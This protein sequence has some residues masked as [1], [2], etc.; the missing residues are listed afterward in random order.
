MTKESV[1]SERLLDTAI[2]AESYKDRRLS[3]TK[4]ESKAGA[5]STLTATNTLR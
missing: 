3:T 1:E 5:G 2:H 4:K